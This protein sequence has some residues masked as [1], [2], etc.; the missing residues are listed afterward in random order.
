MKQDIKYIKD[1]PPSCEYKYDEDLWKRQHGDSFVIINCHSSA[2]YYPEHWTPLSIKCAFNGKEYYKLSNTTYAVNDQ[3][4]LVLNEGAEYAS[5]ILSESITESLTL[6]FTQTNLQFLSAA[7]KNTE[8]FLLDDPFIAKNGNTS[9]I[10]KLYSFTGEMA[11]YIQLI[12]K[13]SKDSKPDNFAIQETLYKLLVELYGLNSLSRNESETIT[14]KKRVTREELYKRLSIVK[15]YLH[16]CYQEEITLDDLALA[17]YLNPCYLLREFK[18]LY[19]VTPHQYLTG[20]R[21]QEARRMIKLSQK[22]ISQITNEIGFQDLASFS[23]LFKKKFDMTPTEYR[24]IHKII[25]E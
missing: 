23:K 6:N 14:A 2:I 13:I 11:T 16:S 15:D 7:E 22:S 9:F 1:F 20:I 10:Q 25:S 18:K 3:N 21:L 5:Y 12:K 17:S 8:Q 19:R 4:F 24:H